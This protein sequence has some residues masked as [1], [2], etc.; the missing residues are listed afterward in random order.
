MRRANYLDRQSR[1]GILRKM[2]T[3]LFQTLLDLQRKYLSLEEYRKIAPTQTVF[4]NCPDGPP[5][6][7]TK[8][9][10][11]AVAFFKHSMINVLNLTQLDP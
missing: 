8:A 6:K 4:Y 5:Q 7:G 1:A 3:Q 11:R 9:H 2:R 10:R